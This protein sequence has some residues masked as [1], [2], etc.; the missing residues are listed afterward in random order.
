MIYDEKL[1]LR[2]NKELIVIHKKC[3]TTHLSLRNIP[4]KTRIKFFKLYD[5]IIDETNI[6]KV[7]NLNIHLFIK[8]L[9]RDELDNKS[10]YTDNT[11]GKKCVKL[12]IR[13]KKG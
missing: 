8:A 2:W 5:S 13:K 10:Y 1:L 11:I 3:I 9:V 6:R 7:Y 12:K 4:Y